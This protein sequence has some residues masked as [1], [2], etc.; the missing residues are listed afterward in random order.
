M[1]LNLSPVF[2]L[3]RDYSY[4]FSNHDETVM[5]HAACNVES[6][7]LNCWESVSI[8]QLVEITADVHEIFWQKTCTAQSASRQAG[9]GASTPEASSDTVRVGEQDEGFS[10]R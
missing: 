3:V 4:L 2:S 5:N 9:H 7:P 8:A 6:R 1:N 10:D